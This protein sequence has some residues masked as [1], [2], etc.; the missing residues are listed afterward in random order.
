MNSDEADQPKM[1]VENRPPKPGL[2][3]RNKEGG[4]VKESDRDEENESDDYSS[5]SEEDG[6]V[7]MQGK[8]STIVKAN[9][10]ARTPAEKKEIATNK[11]QNRNVYIQQMPIQTR[12]ATRGLKRSGNPSDSVL[13][14]LPRA[15]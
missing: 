13:A 10:R 12:A 1:S 9:T 8:S 4:D 6:P 2:Q 7:D 15:K 14:K 11:A 3:L 5:E